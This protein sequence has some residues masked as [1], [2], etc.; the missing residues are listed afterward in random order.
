MS[1]SA[2]NSATAEAAAESIS[3]AEAPFK[4]ASFEARLASTLLLFTL[5]AAMAF[6]VWMFIV[7]QIY[8]PDAA[9]DSQVPEE[10]DALQKLAIAIQTYQIN[11]AGHVDLNHIELHLGVDE[12]ATFLQMDVNQDRI[13]SREDAVPV[14]E[15]LLLRKEVKP[16]GMEVTD[17]RM[18]NVPLEDWERLGGTLDTFRF[19]DAN[20][21]R[22]LALDDLGVE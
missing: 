21:N 4:K 14:L 3:D 18:N 12:A 5:F 10:I 19:L 1:D 16:I 17:A 2:S 11:E 9:R 6:V 22:S 20:G 8:D 13:L 7:D 15:S